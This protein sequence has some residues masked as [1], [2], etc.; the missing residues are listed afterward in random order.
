MRMTA[1]VGVFDLRVGSVLESD[2]AGS[3][4]DCAAHSVVTFL[5]VN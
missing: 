1:S 5:N 3:M 4:N 2:V